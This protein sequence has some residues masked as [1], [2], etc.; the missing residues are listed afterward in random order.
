MTANIERNSTK[1]WLARWIEFNEFVI[2]FNLI[3][4]IENKRTHIDDNTL[5]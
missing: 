5:V 3:N 2:L 1:H 4:K